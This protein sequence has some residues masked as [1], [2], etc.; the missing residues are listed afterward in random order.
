MKVGTVITGLPGATITGTSPEQIIN[1]SFPSVP[2]G[3]LIGQILAKNSN[4]D[5]DTKWIDNNELFG[6]GMPNGVVTASKGVYYTDKNGTNGAWRWVK[7][8]STGNTGWK[9][10]SGDTGWINIS[11]YFDTIASKTT[12]KLILIRRVNDT[13]SFQFHGTLSRS[14]QIVVGENNP[15]YGFGFASR[16]DSPGVSTVRMQVNAGNVMVYGTINVNDASVM[17]FVDTQFTDQPWPVVLP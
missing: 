11:S 9:V 16:V 8:T 14:G 2:T 3:G 1:F 4:D 13:V 6:L 12:S 17:H 5:Y 15:F 10:V 7:T